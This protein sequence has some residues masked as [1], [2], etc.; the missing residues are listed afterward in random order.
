MAGVVCVWRPLSWVGV[1]SCRPVPLVLSCFPFCVVLF[2]LLLCVVGGEVRWCVCAVVSCCGGACGVSLHGCLSPP[3]ICVCC[4]SI[5]GLG[6]CLC[7]R[8]VSLW[9]SGDG[10]CGVEG[11]WVCLLST[12][13]CQLF[14]CCGVCFSVVCVV[15]LCCVVGCG[16][17]VGWEG[18]WSCCLSSSCVGVRGSARA[19]LR[20]RTLSPN[21]IVFPCCVLSLLI[22]AFLRAPSFLLLW[23]G[24]V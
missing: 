23:N 20:A 21:T 1:P 10:L 22:P 3:S 8:V 4:H 17:A 5:V 24:G 18:V 2:P 19:A 11:R 16:M 9:N 13:H 14:V 7:D 12:V 15:L 6:L